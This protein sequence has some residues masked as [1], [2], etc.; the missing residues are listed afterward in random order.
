M[1]KTGVE[2]HVRPGHGQ[3]D[4]QQHPEDDKMPGFALF[5][6]VD[7]QVVFFAFGQFFDGALTLGF[8]CGLGFDFGLFALVGRGFV[9]GRFFI[10]L[11]AGIFIGRFTRLFIGFGGRRRFIF[12]RRFFGLFRFVRF[13][14]FGFGRFRNIGGWFRF[15]GFRSRFGRS[16][17]RFRGCRRLGGLGGHD[18]FLCPGVR[19]FGFQQRGRQQLIIGLF[20]RFGRTAGGFIFFWQ[21]D[22]IGYHRVF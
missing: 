19:F 5:D 16:F 20:G 4:R 13:G 2:G 7:R 11:L 6:G 12:G 10:G 1:D 9:V 22:L 15:V 17:H 8:F 18:L 21:N 14:F 3:Q